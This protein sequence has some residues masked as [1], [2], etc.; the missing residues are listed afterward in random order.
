[1]NCAFKFSII[2][3]GNFKSL[4]K[5]LKILVAIR[6]W[7]AFYYDRLEGERDCC[8][9]E[10]TPL[11]RWKTVFNGNQRDGGFLP[12]SVFGSC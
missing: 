2:I 8:K 10:K 7:N 12:L 1:M 6:E 11:E 9:T 5:C 3:R 4:Q